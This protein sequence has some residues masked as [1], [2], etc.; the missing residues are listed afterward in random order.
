[1]DDKK[2]VHFMSGFINDIMDKAKKK[3]I[4]VSYVDG[5]V[6]SP[7]AYEFDYDRVDKGLRYGQAEMIDAIVRNDKGL[8]TCC[9]GAGKSFVIKQLCKAYS[10]ANILIVT[11]AASV[12]DSLYNDISGELGKDAVGLIKGGTHGSEEDKRVRVCTTKSIHRSNIKQ[13]DILIFDEVHNVGDNAIGD[14]LTMSGTQAKMFGFSASMHRGDRAQQIIK[15]LFGDEIATLTY[16]E[17]VEH[18]VVTKIDA[19]M[20][21]YKGPAII[22]TGKSYLD[23]PRF[24]WSNRHRNER[25]A[26]AC[27][28]IPDELQTLIMVDTLEHAINLHQLL[29][30]YTVIH[31]GGSNSTSTKKYVQWDED[32]CPDEV[33]VVHK[34]AGNVESLKRIPDELGRVMFQNSKGVTFNAQKLFK[35]YTTIEGGMCGYQK[36]FKRIIKGI[37]AEEYAITK[38]Q[39]AQITKDFESGKLKKVIATKIWSEGINVKHCRFFFRANGSSSKNDSI[40]MPGRLSRLMEGKDNAVLLDIYDDFNIQVKRKAETRRKEYI[41]QGW[42]T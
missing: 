33:V 9:T 31:F 24:Y 18:G 40:Q 22:P 5:R 19:I 14:A 4:N 2:G 10:N 36:K 28:A 37:D 32:E 35:N 3:G 11:K 30:E 27:R 42:M 25:I 12:V 6:H 13:C 39:K 23:N 21:P 29:P 16:Q 38:D 1:M 15:G 26:E 34:T 20:I 7:K 17:G 8:I 41:K